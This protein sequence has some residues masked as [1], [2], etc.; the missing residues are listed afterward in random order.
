MH[1][2]LWARFVL[3]FATNAYILLPTCWVAS[4]GTTWFVLYGSEQDLGVGYS[5]YRKTSKRIPMYVTCFLQ[6][7]WDGSSRGMWVIS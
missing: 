5:R 2:S 6:L 4:N 1:M 7:L 3:P